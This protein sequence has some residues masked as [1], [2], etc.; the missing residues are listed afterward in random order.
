MIKPQTGKCDRLNKVISTSDQQRGQETEEEKLARF[1]RVEQETTIGAFNLFPAHPIDFR[2]RDFVPALR[3]G[4]VE[5]SQNFLQVD[6]LAGWHE[7]GSL[8]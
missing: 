2:G 4:R 6:F 8:A 7:E 3:T 1:L 5:G